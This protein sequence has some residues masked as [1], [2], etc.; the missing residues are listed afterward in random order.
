MEARR[1]TF[2]A[3][4]EGQRTAGR[5]LAWRCKL[6]ISLFLDGSADGGARGRIQ[7]WS[8]ARLRGGRRR[9]RPQEAAGDR[10]GL[11]RAADPGRGLGVGAPGRPAGHTLRGLRSP[12]LP[13]PVSSISRILRSKF[14][15][16]EEEEV[17]LER[18]EA[19]ESEKKA[20]HSI[21]G[22]LS[23]RGKRRAGRTVALWRGGPRAAQLPRVSGSPGSCPRRRERRAFHEG[24]TCN[25]NERFLF[26][27]LYFTNL[28][29]ASPP[30][31]GSRRL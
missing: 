13:P 19:E 24:R 20:K 11:C 23:E 15:K 4:S 8:N 18:K 17:D 26:G 27:F 25:R 5:G 2:P 10:S 16:G 31:P 28:P 7:G 12:L 3:G 6:P 22:I 21:D 30:A 14:G 1:E 29:S 9:W